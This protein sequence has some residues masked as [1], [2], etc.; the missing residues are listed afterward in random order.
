MNSV[1][2]T[3][4]LEAFFS[5]SLDLLC[6]ADTSGTFLRVNRAWC[7]TLGYSIDELQNRNFMEFVHPDDRGPTL[8]E[9]SRLKRQ[10]PVLN[11]VNRYRHRDGTFRSIEWR[12]QQHDGFIYAAARDV[13]AQ[14][15]REQELHQ[16]KELLDLF[17]RQS[18]DG[19]FFMM[20]D[21]PVE[22]TAET[23]KPAVMEYVFAHHRITRINGAMLEQ[24]RAQESDFVGLTPNDLF[25]HD[26]GYGKQVWTDFF[27]RGT[28][29]LDTQEMKFDGT[30]MIIEGDYICLYDASGR[31]T[32]HFGIQREVTFEREAASRLRESEER[33]RQLAENIEQVF[34]LRSGD[35]ILYLSP[36]YEKTWGVPCTGCSDDS[37]H[38]FDAIHPD[39]RRRVLQKI[40]ENPTGYSIEYRIIRPD[41]TVRWIWER[42]FPV[43]N[44]TITDPQTPPRSAAIAQ[45]ITERRMLEQ[46]LRDAAIRDPLTGLFNRRHLFERLE[47][48]WA[49]HRRDDSPFAIAILDIDHFK[50]INDQYGHLAG[51]AV[52][53]SFASLIAANSRAYDLTARFGGEEFFIVYQDTTRD[54][55]CDLIQRTL[56]TVRD[57][58]FPFDGHEITVTASCGI[59]DNSDGE[60][61]LDIV[62]TA[63]R[64]L[65]QAKSEGR[66]RVVA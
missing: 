43:Q 27:D 12:S 10:E 39:D 45:D 23:D 6:V 55:A 64:R 51:D 41:G 52:L 60:S 22:W 26:I 58:V 24:Y 21:E 37:A 63:D 48:I 28:L 33:F 44:E 34:I 56:S 25:Q 32:G 8:E 36:A 30:P 47:P 42:S 4:N 40:G 5:V 11:F 14:K 66:D 61:V 16:S 35:E 18:L 15:Q 7:D 53:T 57:M 62:A 54:Q 1:P 20:L 65:Y 31:I 38:Y 17:F 19:F 59:A 50:A 13:T 9:I 29:H 46:Q 2:V 3:I 49:K